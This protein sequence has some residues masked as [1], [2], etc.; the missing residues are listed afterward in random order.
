MIGVTIAVI[1]VLSKTC[2]C[3][4][5]VPVT[6]RQV[7]PEHDGHD[8]RRDDAQHDP[9][10]QHAPSVSL[11][12]HQTTSRKPSMKPIVCIGPPKP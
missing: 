8:R 1:T 11:C 9:S 10:E 7:R 3:A 4:W 2:S 6:G 12:R 5:S